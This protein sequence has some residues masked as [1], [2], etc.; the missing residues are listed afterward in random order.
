MR[1]GTSI[2]LMLV[3]SACSSP[4][5]A[6]LPTRRLTSEEVNRAAVDL[7]GTVDFAEYPFVLADD[8]RIDG[9][10]GLVEGQTASAYQAERLQAAAANFA[11]A[12][13][14]SPL[15]SLCGDLDGLSPDQAS[16]CLH[17]S[18]L[19]FAQR[20]WRRPIGA[21][22]RQRLLGFV[23]EATA[24]HGHEAAAILAVQAIFQSP[25]FLYLGTPTPEPVDPAFALAEQMAFF[26]WD[27]VPD[28]ALFEA[29]ATGKLKTEAQVRA[30][31]QRMLADPRARAALVRFH[32]QWLELEEVYTAVPDMTTYMAKY[33]PTVERPQ[34]NDLQD[35]EEVWTA[36]LIAIRRG[37]LLEAQKFV[38]HTL[39]D[40]G[41]TLAA[42]LTDHHGFVTDV[43]LDEN[44]GLST[45]DIYGV[46]PDQR[47][48]QPS[49]AL[50]FEDGNFGF[51]IELQAATYPQDQRAGV[52]TL[53]AVL[54]SQAHP[55]HP[56]PVLRGK[57]LLER[58]ACME[59]G[60]P[61][62]SAAGQAPAD[63]PD[64]ASTN[65]ARLEAVTDPPACNACHQTINPAGFSMEHY[66]SMGGYRALDN[67]QP[68]D[69]S[70]TL[71]I[72]PGE[73]Y[74]TSNIVELAQ[75][76]ATSRTVHDCYA[77][78]WSRYALGRREAT[79]DGAA[80]AEVQGKFYAS[81]G[82]VRRLLED[83]VV[84]LMFAGAP[85]ADA[86]GGN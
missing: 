78:Q 42:L 38:E 75:G 8:V 25:Q 71:T 36:N 77:L 1:T 64:A 48:A 22:E 58:F 74:A 17:E 47:L 45:A 29:A 59:L 43:I 50:D 35:F 70:G 60:Q 13:P 49:Y 4:P 46:S 86:P 12:T 81:G 67:E 57:L 37:M 5:A 19:K 26:L 20:A 85:H 62:D 41:G 7:L 32:E 23:D 53:G 73:T 18:V 51:R 69:A 76:L 84:N 55:V 61:P 56:A 34:D 3:L 39:F 80:I 52:L 11:D 68:V 30:Q 65:R 6:D 66:D 9:F 33:L 82:D 16:A 24:R 15:F 72:A 2:C 83:I 27:S 63:S 79:S 40:G 31:V 28:Q 21:A 54:T 10:D 14:E 44:P